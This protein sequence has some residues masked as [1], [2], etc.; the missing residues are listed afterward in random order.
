MT[1]FAP[2][3]L[4]VLALAAAVPAAFADDSTP[5]APAATTPATTTTTNT[6]ASPTTPHAHAHPFARIRLQLLRL[7]L[8]LVRLEY[9][10]VC[11]DQSSDRCAQFTQKLITRLTNLDNAVEQRMAT[12]NCTSDGTDKRCVLLAK[13]DAKLKDVIQKLQSGTAPSTSDESG[14]DNAASSLAAGS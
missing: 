11:H 13:I 2:L 1:R 14:L 9:R 8:R 3:L 6:T 5:P 10:V 4:V 12:L 7:R